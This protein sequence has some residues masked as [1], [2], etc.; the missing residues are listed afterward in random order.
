[1]TPPPSH[2]TDGAPGELPP[3][4]AAAGF[5]DWGGATLS[6][7]H[8]FI[9]RYAPEEDR[10]LDLHVDE[11]DVTFNFGLSAPDG[12]AGSDLVFC[13]MFGAPDH[14]CHSHTYAHVQGRCVLHSGKVVTTRATTNS[15][16]QTANNK[17]QT[18][19]N[20]QQTTNNKQQTTNN[21]QQQRLQN[22]HHTVR[23]NT[24][25]SPP[26]HSPPHS[27]ESQRRRTTS[28]TESSSRQFATQRE[29]SR[30][31]RVRPRVRTPPRAS[32]GTARSTYRA[33]SA[34]A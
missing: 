23:V 28:R 30:P 20:K 8:T 5:D 15:K 25:E 31:L 7:H 32:G 33:A 26:R 29:R 10:H 4:V 2:A 34:R 3:P 11:C 1:M 13:G 22:T 21:K 9:V 6:D 14:R 19:N 16:Q 18:T 27:F 12:F 17:Q 24:H